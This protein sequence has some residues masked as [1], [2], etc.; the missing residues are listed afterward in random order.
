MNVAGCTTRRPLSSEKTD[1]VHIVIEWAIPRAVLDAVAK[2]KR[3]LR[4]NS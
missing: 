4:Q 1:H 3:I 2:I